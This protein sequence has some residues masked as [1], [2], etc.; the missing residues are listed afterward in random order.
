MSQKWW[1][2]FFIFEHENRNTN[3]IGQLKIQSVDYPAKKY[4]ISFEIV[5]GLLL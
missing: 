5:N 4:G 2:N 3:H 1:P